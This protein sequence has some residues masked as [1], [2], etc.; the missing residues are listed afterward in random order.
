M[1]SVPGRAHPKSKFAPDEDV[2][3]RDLVWRFGT[4]NWTQVAQFMWH[5]NERQCKER[6]FNYLSPAVQFHPWTAEED[7]RLMEKVR[8]V[9]PKWVRIT[10]FFPWRTS[11]QVKNRF[12]VLSR[13][14]KKEQLTAE[15]GS[16]A[17]RVD[18]ALQFDSP[19][20]CDSIPPL[21][22]RTQVCPEI[23]PPA[24]DQA[25]GSPIGCAPD[26]PPRSAA[27]GLD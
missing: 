6:W 23:C 17:G 16:E 21:L 24:Q 26:S 18:V 8:A 11:N 9:G 12:L 1:L 2:L 14:E 25:A 13:Q 4:N 7:Q 5:R 15:G 3:L 27:L 10:A 20:A 19:F 22:P